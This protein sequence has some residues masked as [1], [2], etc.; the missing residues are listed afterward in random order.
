MSTGSSEVVTPSDLTGA[1]KVGENKL[2][3]PV[4]GLSA[5]GIII[6]ISGY[7]ASTGLGEKTDLSNTNNSVSEL[8]LAVGVLSAVTL[9][10]LGVKVARSAYIF[11]EIERASEARLGE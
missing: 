7:I 5:V 2:I 4:A 3:V 1:C 10:A 11:K 9:T 8:F 6:S